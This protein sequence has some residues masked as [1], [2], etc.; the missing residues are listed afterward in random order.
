MMI[1]IEH[2]GETQSPVTRYIA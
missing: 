2:V 1:P